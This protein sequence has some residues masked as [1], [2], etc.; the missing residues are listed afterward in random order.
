MEKKNIIDFICYCMVNFLCVF[1]VLIFIH[2]I[3]MCY[4]RKKPD[5]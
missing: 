5:N 2:F 1:A 4:M 3:S